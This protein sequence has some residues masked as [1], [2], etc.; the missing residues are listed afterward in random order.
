MQ[1]PVSLA[2]APGRLSCVQRPSLVFLGLRMRQ[3]PGASLPW[4]S[5][6]CAV[7]T[8]PDAQAVSAVVHHRVR[9]PADADHIGAARRTPALRAAYA[10][11]APLKRALEEALEIS[12]GGQL[13]AF[14]AHA[15]DGWFQ[16]L[17]ERARATEP[18]WGALRVELASLAWPLVLFG[19]LPA[20][21]EQ[22]LFGHYGLTLGDDAESRAHAELA[23]YRALVYRLAF[24][25]LT[26]TAVE[27]G[28][29][30]SDDDAYPNAEV[31]R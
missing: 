19:D 15:R 5:E 13:V 2:A 29:R 6:I 8:D 22:A 20:I 23:L 18:R 26:W 16:L 9:P 11:G 24:A 17:C 21:G 10:A 27:A 3:V 28:A 4:L 30:G 1:E 12:T 14:N 25:E 7:R 31:R